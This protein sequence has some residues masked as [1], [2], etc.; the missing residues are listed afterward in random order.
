MAISVTNNDGPIDLP[1]PVD[2][3]QLPPSNDDDIELVIATFSEHMQT[4]RLN[5]NEWRGPL[6]IEQ[7]LK[8]EKHLLAQDLTKDGKEVAWLL[9]S[10]RLPLDQDGNRSI[11]A[12][13]ETIP[14][15]AYCAQNGK[16]KEVL[17][18]GIGS[19]FTRSEHRGKSYASR[20]MTE[21]GKK[22]ETFQQHN[23]DRSPFSVLYSDIGQKFYSRFGWQ[24]FA[25]THIHLAA[26][27]DGDYQHFSKDLPAVTDL[28]ADDLSSIPATDYL[29]D[30]LISVSRS[31]PARL[32]SLWRLIC[33]ISGGTMHERTLS[34]RPWADLCP[35]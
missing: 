8:R 27:T 16:L 18:H 6:T 1:P 26:M 9:T 15:Q 32:S 14:M 33:P 25:S 12:S 4:S 19:V 10:S 5:G 23:G 20:M 2:S 11:L 3:A 13:C 34:Q 28:M 21:L 24:A 22:L 35:K 30:D 17:I 31:N 29:K 7:Y